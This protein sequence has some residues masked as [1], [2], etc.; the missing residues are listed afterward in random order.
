MDQDFRDVVK[1]ISKLFVITDK[2]GSAKV[3]LTRKFRTEEIVIEFHCQDENTDFN[4]S[5][6]AENWE[7]EG[8]ETPE[9]DQNLDYGH[10]FTVTVK[11][12]G[13]SMEFLCNAGQV[14]TVNQMMHIPS[15]V[16]AD[17]DLDKLYRGPQFDN[18]DEKLQDDIIKYLADR[19]VGDDMAFFVISY[20]RDKEEREYRQWLKNFLSLVE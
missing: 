17:K 12:G 15:G 16:T 6:R 5:E 4:G 10:D 9:E 18:L 8:G 19:G 7:E 14:I 1:E 11:K 2:P 13:N 3:V 20:A